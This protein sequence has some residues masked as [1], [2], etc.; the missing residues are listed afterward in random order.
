VPEIAL[1][2]VFPLCA[3][4]LARRRFPRNRVTA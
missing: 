2:G 1:A 3:A 4:A